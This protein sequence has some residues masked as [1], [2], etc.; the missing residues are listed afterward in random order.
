MAI[1][2][3]SEGVP[4]MSASHILKMSLLGSLLM[5]AACND[6]T[7]P[8]ASPSS[9][10]SS[11]VARK[12]NG[13]VAPGVYGNV[14]G[15]SAAGDLRGMEV[16]VH[17]AH[18]Q[19]IEVTLCKGQCAPIRRTPYEIK[20]GGIVFAIADG[21]VSPD[22]K[23]ARLLSFR[24]TPKGEDA[25]A[26]GTGIDAGPVLLKHLDKRTGLAMAEE[27]FRKASGVR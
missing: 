17:E 7:T 22:G 21:A 3:K 26:Q 2:G 11:G 20:D 6:A 25:M 8:S 5:L 19:M 1:M 14:Q 27:S 16:E 24:L 4:I 18:G 12:G 13:P 23:P 9:G 15:S 10:P